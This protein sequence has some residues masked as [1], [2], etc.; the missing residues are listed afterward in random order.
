MSFYLLLHLISW[1]DL[2]PLLKVCLSHNYFL[3]SWKWGDYGRSRLEIQKH[4]FL[5]VDA[6]H[7]PSSLTSNLLSLRKKKKKMMKRH[8][9]VF[10]VRGDEEGNNCRLKSGRKWG[11]FDGRREFSWGKKQEKYQS[12]RKQIVPFGQIFYRNF[13]HFLWFFPK[14]LVK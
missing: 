12:W 1:F 9:E 6:N 7:Q 5:D 8:R 3:M 11:S 13:L 2:I 10:I 4:S 14:W